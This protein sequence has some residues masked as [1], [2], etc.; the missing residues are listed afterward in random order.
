MRTMSPPNELIGVNWATDVKPAALVVVAAPSV[1]W[2]VPR[3]GFVGVVAA[4][5][6]AVVCVMVMNGV[7]TQR[8]SRRWMASIRS[9]R[10]GRGAGPPGG[11][12][13]GRD[14]PDLLGRDS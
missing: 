1:I 12:R 11:R 4:V 6:V 2:T 5:K 8:S 10:R 13:V 14:I 3:R 7:R 9:W